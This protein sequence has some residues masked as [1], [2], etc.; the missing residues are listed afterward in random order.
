MPM[1]RGKRGLLALFLVALLWW[2][3]TT[4]T[5]SASGR[6]QVPFHPDSGIYVGASTAW[7]ARADTFATRAVAGV[8]RIPVAR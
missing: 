1:S 6:E 2:L 5:G 7:L 8:D 4:P 3:P